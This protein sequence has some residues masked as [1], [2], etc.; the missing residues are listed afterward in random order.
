MNLP[1]ADQTMMEE[2]PG[3]DIEQ[4]TSLRKLLESKNLLDKLSDE[5]KEELAAQVSE[6][7]EYD[8]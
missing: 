5:Q 4:E 6:G 1:Q 8:Q 7:F 2:V 3:Q